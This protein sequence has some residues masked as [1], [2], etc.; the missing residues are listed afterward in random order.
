[1]ARDE[2]ILEDLMARI[3]AMV[4]LPPGQWLESATYNPDVFD[5]TLGQL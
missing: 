3:S 1:M 2:A 4:A 5:I